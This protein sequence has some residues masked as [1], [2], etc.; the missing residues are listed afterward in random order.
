MRTTALANAIPSHARTTLAHIRQAKA[1]PRNY[2]G[3]RVFANDG[4]ANGQVLPRTGASG[5]AITYQE[6]DVHPYQRGVNRGAERLVTG[7]DGKA[8]YTS[9]HYTTFTEVK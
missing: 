3:G 7:S 8:Y 1:A 6:W 5:S 2:K 9:D 4:R